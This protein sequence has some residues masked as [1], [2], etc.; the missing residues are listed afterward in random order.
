MFEDAVEAFCGL[1]PQL[2]PVD[3]TGHRGN[4][5]EKGEEEEEE[6]MEEGSSL[7]VG[8]FVLCHWSDGLYY[9]GKIQRVRNAQTTTTLERVHLTIV[10]KILTTCY[11]IFN[12]IVQWNKIILNLFI[13][14][15]IYGVEKK[16]NSTKYL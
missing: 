15:H 13:Q 2:S 5:Q 3:E 4:G 9:L 8:Q 12:D 14:L 10:V 6:E 1:E 16:S 11:K 7:S